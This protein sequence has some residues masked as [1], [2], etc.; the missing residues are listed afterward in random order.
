M[1]L[2]DYANEINSLHTDVRLEVMLAELYNGGLDPRTDVLVYPSGLFERSYRRDVGAVK[3]GHADALLQELPDVD[4]SRRTYLNIEVHRDGLYDYLPE[5]L[6]HQPVNRG[7]DQKEVFDDI[8]EQARRKQAA[9]QF[10]Q[11]FEQEFF[12]QRTM[13]ELEER[14]YQINEENLRRNDQGDV[15]RQ[16]WGISANLLNTRQLHN[17]LH[18]LPLA[19]RLT[20]NRTLVT[21]CF[22]VILGV[23]VQLRTIPPLIHLIELAPDDEPVSNELSRAELGNFSLEGAYQDTMPAVEISIGPLDKR[24]LNDFLVGGR[25]RAVL[26]L[27]IGYFLPAELD[28]VDHLITDDDNS[29]LV[30]SDDDPTAVLGVASYI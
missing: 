10:F 8:D 6:F 11:P 5:G 28:V 14:K 4:E 21:E 18:L 7:R 19:H 25:S 9:R 24:Q 22:E 29:F 2:T 1:K 13:L 27:L 15:L 26:D 3:V 16:F 20:Q 30:L 12:L 23:P 17:L